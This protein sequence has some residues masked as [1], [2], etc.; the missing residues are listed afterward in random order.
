M[1]AAETLLARIHKEGSIDGDVIKVDS[2]LNHM[3][4]PPTF[5]KS[6]PPIWLNDLKVEV[7]IKS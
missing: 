6:W 5:S 3:S 1:T 4:T 2:F 7:P